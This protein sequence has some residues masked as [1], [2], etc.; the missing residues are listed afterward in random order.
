MA[1]AGAGFN[2]VLHTCNTTLPQVR[3]IVDI[4]FFL[5]STRLFLDKNHVWQAFSNLIAKT[6]F[7]AFVA[8]FIG[9]RGLGLGLLSLDYAVASVFFCINQHRVPLCVL[10]SL[11]SLGHSSVVLLSMHFGCALSFAIMSI[12]DYSPEHITTYLF[13]DCTQALLLRIDSFFYDVTRLCHE[14]GCEM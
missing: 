2:K 12:L 1:F 5:Y 4:S 9:S 7:N 10:I 3:R 11:I 14:S 6:S 13:L 8:T